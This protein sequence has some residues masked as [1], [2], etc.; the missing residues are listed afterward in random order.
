MSFVRFFFLVL[1]SSSAAWSQQAIIN[2]PSADITP[3][4]KNFLMNE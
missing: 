3:V 4:G 2:L 1:L